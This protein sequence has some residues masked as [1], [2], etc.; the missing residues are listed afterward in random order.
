MFSM[1]KQQKD[2]AV[3]KDD[4]GIAANGLKSMFALT[5]YYNDYFENKLT[6][7]TPETE[8]TSALVVEKIKKDFTTFKKE[9][10]FVDSNGN[11]ENFNIATISDVQLSRVQKDLLTKAVGQFETFKSDAAIAMSGFTSAATDNAKE[12]LMA[13]INATVELASMHIYMLTLGFTPDQISEIMTCDVIENILKRLETNIFFNKNKPSVNVI[14]A[15]IHKEQTEAK[16][17]KDDSDVVNLALVTDI[18]Q[19]AQEMKL[20]S[21]LLGVNQKASANTEELNKFLNNFENIVYGRENAIFGK[22]LNILRDVFELESSSSIDSKEN[23]APEMWNNIINLI[24]K[25]NK[26]LDPKSKLD[27]EHIKSVIRKAN[28]ISVNYTNEIGERVTKNVSLIGG[29]FDNRYYIDKDNVEYRQVTKE[30]YNL[31]KNTFNVFDVIEQVPHFKEMIDSVILSHNILINSAFMYNFVF[32][33][34][35]DTVRRNSNRVVFSERE[36]NSHIKNQMANINFPPK[37]G[38]KEVTN[39]I[40]GVH[41]MSKDL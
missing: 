33:N 34:L 26:Q 30:Y 3:G 40:L 37:I 9:F 41:I 14:L 19:G 17:S 27:R 5:S 35:K 24:C 13:K 6:R 36:I 20:L 25:Y 38:K 22:K 29:K 10:K 31:I 12:L 15:N 23:K 11:V 16:L 2:A 39:S 1:Y 32:S 21:S 8:N 18:Y 28:K 4:V 7:I